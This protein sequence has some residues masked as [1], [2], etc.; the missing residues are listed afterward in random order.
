MQDL[1]QVLG[2]KLN[3]WEFREAWEE[4]SM[5]YDFLDR[6]ATV[7]AKVAHNADETNN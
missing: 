4:S 2:Q 7:C 6:I 3:S 1:A 5:E